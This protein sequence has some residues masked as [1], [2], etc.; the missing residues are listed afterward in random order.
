MI[1]IVQ[2]HLQYLHVKMEYVQLIFTLILIKKILDLHLT[3]LNL[4]FFIIKIFRNPQN[5]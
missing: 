3:H 2:Q 4:K 1:K 5:S